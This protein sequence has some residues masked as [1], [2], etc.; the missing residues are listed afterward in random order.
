MLNYENLFTDQSSR[1]EDFETSPRKVL[2]PHDE[3]K[4]G[5]R[6]YEFLRIS[7]LSK[8]LTSQQTIVSKWLSSCLIKVESKGPDNGKLFIGQHFKNLF[9]L[10]VLTWSLLLS[11]QGYILK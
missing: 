5:W 10:N 4:R 7:M 11:P 6:T 9:M 3:N 1:I 2:K 8:P